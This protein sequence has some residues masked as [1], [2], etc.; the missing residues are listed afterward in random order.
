[1][2]NSG[3]YK[4]AGLNYNSSKAGSYLPMLGNCLPIKDSKVKKN[5]K[6]TKV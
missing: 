5:L 2:T 1:L 6:T 4:T 3:I